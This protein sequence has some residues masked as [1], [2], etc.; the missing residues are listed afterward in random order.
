LPTTASS[1]QAIA[2]QPKSLANVAID[3][4]RWSVAIAARP[5][6]LPFGRLI[7]DSIVFPPEKSGSARQYLGS[8]PLL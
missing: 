8:R 1:R 2:I 4:R 7:V 6:S 3:A 5:R